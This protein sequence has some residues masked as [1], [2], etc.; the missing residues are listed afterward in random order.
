MLSLAPTTAI[1]IVIF[2]CIPLINEEYS[3]KNQVIDEL[4]ARRAVDFVF[5][6]LNEL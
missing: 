4:H 1:D 5:L 2:F 3:Q 6:R